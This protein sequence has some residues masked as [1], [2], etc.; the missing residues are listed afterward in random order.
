MA[1][2]GFSYLPRPIINQKTNLA[3]DVFTPYIPIRLSVSHNNPTPIIDALVD[4]GSDRNLFPIELGKLLGINFKKLKP[5]IIFGIGDVHI[6]AYT[7]NIN[8]WL[9]N[10]KYSSEADFSPDQQ[11]L[12]LGRQGFF[13]LFKT[14]IFDEKGR[15]LY[16]E[17]FDLT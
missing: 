14:V 8:I 7:A 4:S 12:L 17:T 10:I 16:I 11:T 2:T 9:N 6:K 3:E 5:K 13:N 15:F 1:K